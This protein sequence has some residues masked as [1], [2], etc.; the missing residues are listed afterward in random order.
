MVLLKENCINLTI[1]FLRNGTVFKE[2]SDHMHSGLIELF[3]LQVFLTHE[4]HR[5]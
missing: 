1:L 2:L 4:R 3:V 5:P